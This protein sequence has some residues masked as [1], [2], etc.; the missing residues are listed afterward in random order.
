MRLWLN[1]NGFPFMLKFVM[2]GFLITVTIVLQLVIPLVNVTG[3][4]TINSAFKEVAKK[5]KGNVHKGEVFDTMQHPIPQPT[6]QHG[7]ALTDAIVQ[8]SGCNKIIVDEDPPITHIIMSREI[9]TTMHVGD[10][11]KFMEEAS[12]ITVETFHVQVEGTLVMAEK[13]KGN[14]HSNSFAEMRITSPWCDAV[15]DMDYYNYHTLD[16]L[17]YELGTN[18][19]VVVT[20]SNLSNISANVIH[21]MQVLKLVPSVAQHTM[22]FFLVIPRLTWVRKKK[23]LI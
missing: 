22:D 3:C 19:F 12:S 10:A 4:I 20:N 1:V 9:A 5:Q 21:D 16:D 15:T 17:E 13:P 18:S 6:R 14:Q 2:N 23:P 8:P 7:V 11:I